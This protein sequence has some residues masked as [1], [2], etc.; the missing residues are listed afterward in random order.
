MVMA[1]EQVPCNPR[2]VSSKEE[3]RSSALWE[4]RTFQVSDMYFL[5]IF[6]K[7]IHFLLVPSGSSGVEECGRGGRKE[8]EQGWGSRVD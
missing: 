4:L 8:R 6:P 5:T 7:C 2:E 3:C 1:L